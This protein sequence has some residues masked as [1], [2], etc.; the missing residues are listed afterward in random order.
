MASTES[1]WTRNQQFALASG[2]IYL[3][4]GILGFAV[5][6]FDGFAA[7]TDDRLI[8]LGLNPAHNVVHLTLG[9]IWLGAALTASA[10]RLVNTGLGFGLLAAFLLG[11]VGGAQFLNI[12]GF[13]EPDNWLHLVYGALSV[14][15]GTRV[16]DAAAEEARVRAG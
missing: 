3:A 1:G 13:S 16:G 2:L 10:A 7:D 14:A 5:T 9:S 11:I 15:V 6:G 4:A 8:I 12:D